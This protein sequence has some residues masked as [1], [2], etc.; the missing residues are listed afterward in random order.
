MRAAA[1]LA[2]AGAGVAAACG[3]P[4]PAEALL[5]AGIAHGGAEVAVA[6]LVAWLAYTAGDVLSLVV[7]RHGVAHRLPA[8]WRGSVDA[9]AELDVGARTVLV[10]RLLPGSAAVNVAAAAGSLPATRFAVAAAVGEA[11][12]VALV[13]ALGGAAVE[14]LGKFAV[15]MALAAWPALV[16]ALWWHRRHPAAVADARGRLRALARDRAVRRR[17]LAA[18]AL[19]G[20]AA[21]VVFVVA[22]R[23]GALRETWTRIAHGEAA[24]LALAGA[25]EVLSYAGYVVL[26][27]A[28]LARSE[29]RIGWRASYQITMAG[30]VASRV[31]ATVGAGGIALTG[32]ALRAAGLE[33]RAV[34]RQLVAFLVL[35][36]S[37]YVAALVVAG[38]GLAGGLL[39]GRAPMALT[40][41]PAA[42]GAVVLVAA[43]L[44]AR[45]V[46]PPQPTP[47][48]SPDGHRGRW[49]GRA[50]AAI[51]VP[52]A[53]IAD[54]LALARTGDPRLLGAVAWW[55]F[56]VA[57]L[58][59][60]LHAFG[61]APPVAVVVVAYFVGM[62][63]NTLPLP[64]G[65]G[66]VEGG[67]IG[68]LIAFAVDPALA[69]A[70]VLAYRAIAFWLPIA[71]GAVAYLGLRRTVA[72]WRAERALAA[73]GV[74]QSEYAAPDVPEPARAT[75]PVSAPADVAPEHPVALPGDGVPDGG[76]TRTA[77]RTRSPS[78][79]CAPAPAC[80]ARSGDLAD[81]AGPAPAHRRRR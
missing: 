66:G 69:L 44:A 47:D 17:A 67:M 35:L 54:A 19:A 73:P 52:R 1:I 29:A 15:P 48:A 7:L 25:L 27:R 42:V 9:V 80:R 53:G 60:C 43:L 16:L 79:A 56:D 50:R 62:L 49:R 20:L 24:W 21:A 5:V 45:G 28:V 68:A 30:V 61:G 65:V 3:L 39:P 23:V 10:S 40:L 81:A 26:F 74:A 38:A 2:L 12:Y 4:S 22:P 13:G 63:A 32:W 71:P 58:W 14:V 6:C 75:P 41:A 36:Y 59:A 31:L 34:G 46:A 33:A 55:G 70:G 72:G 78:P 57:V 64:G 37:V 77:R 18:V 11:G 76:P 8:R 51:A